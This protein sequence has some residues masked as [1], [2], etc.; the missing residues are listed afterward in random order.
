MA[1]LFLRLQ[2]RIICITSNAA[3]MKNIS[4]QEIL[5]PRIKF[6]VAEELPFLQIQLTK[7]HILFQ[8]LLRPE[9]GSRLFCS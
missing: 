8:I 2:L 3:T 5:A 9:F 7:Y 4:E 6:N 1:F